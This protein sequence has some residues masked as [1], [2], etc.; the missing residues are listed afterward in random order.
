MVN[1]QRSGLRSDTWVCTCWLVELESLVF[2]IA[3]QFEEHP[4]AEYYS[5]SGFVTTAFL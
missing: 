5:K 2:V 3:D 1:P 4:M